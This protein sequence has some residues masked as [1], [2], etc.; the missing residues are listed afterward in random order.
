MGGKSGFRLVTTVVIATLFVG[1]YITPA[2]IEISNINPDSKTASAIMAMSALI[3]V[4][5][6]AV[7]LAV[8]PT[9]VAKKAKSFLGVQD[10]NA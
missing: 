5:I 4:E 6:I 1:W 8:L 9:A 2:L 3:S 7:L 10:A